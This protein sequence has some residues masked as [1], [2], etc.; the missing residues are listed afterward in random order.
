LDDSSLEWRQGIQSYLNHGPV[1]VTYRARP[2]HTTISTPVNQNSGQVPMRLVLGL[3][4]LV[5]YLLR[6]CLD[7]NVEVELG[8]SNSN[9][10]E[11][12]A[13]FDSYAVA[14]HKQQT[15]MQ[16]AEFVSSKEVW[17]HGSMM[18]VA[19]L[20][21]L[22]GRTERRNVY[23]PGWRRRCATTAADSCE[24]WDSRPWVLCQSL[25]DSKCLE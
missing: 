10:M 17:P 21:E 11:H 3:A 2:D 18:W 23:M 15:Q 9:N 8:S 16:I 6:A 12:N 22:D 20:W 14:T 7:W 13:G 24:C 4:T 1:E 5:L 19:V 25:R